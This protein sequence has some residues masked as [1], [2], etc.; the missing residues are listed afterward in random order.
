MLVWFYKKYRK[1]DMF[2]TIKLNYSVK[3]VKTYTIFDII[4]NVYNIR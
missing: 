1:Y 4:K 2:V 3:N